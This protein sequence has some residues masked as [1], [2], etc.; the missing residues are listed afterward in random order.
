MCT[1]VALIL[2]LNPSQMSDSFLYATPLPQ[3]SLFTA[4][5][6]LLKLP[7]PVT[8]LVAQASLKQENLSLVLYPITLIMQ[9]VPYLMRYKVG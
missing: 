8:T 9:T 3:C 5:L 1:D 6:F 2:S 7:F 4:A